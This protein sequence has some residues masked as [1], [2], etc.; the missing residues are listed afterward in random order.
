M[1]AKVSVATCNVVRTT[2]KKFYEKCY[3]CYHET[4][5]NPLLLCECHVGKSR[6]K[7]HHERE[8]SNLTSAEKLHAANI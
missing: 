4:A 6:M 8:Y 2:D 7:C 3:K 5:V 1:L